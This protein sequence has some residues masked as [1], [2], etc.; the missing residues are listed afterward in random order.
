MW[1]ARTITCAPQPAT[2]GRKNRGIDVILTDTRQLSRV[3]GRKTDAE[4]C[5]WIQLPHSCGLLQACFRPQ[6]ASCHLRTLVRGKA[7][8]VAER[9][10]WLRR[11]QK[12]L[13]Q[14]N[15][16]VQ[17]AVSDVDGATG[18]PSCGRLWPASAIQSSWRN[19]GTRAA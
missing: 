16:R 4:D 1:K 12:S 17:R 2:A 3:P 7:V 14:M 8:L 5:Q 10:D 6:D 13:D 18:W 19:Y 9:S 15:V 11:M